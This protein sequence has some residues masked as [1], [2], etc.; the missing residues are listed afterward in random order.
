MARTDG[1]NGPLR[2]LGAA[3]ATTALVTALSYGVP[4]EHAASAVGLGFLAA[5]YFLTLRTND[6]DAARRYGLSLGGLLDVEPLSPARLGKSALQELG[7]A[8]A[9]CAVVLPP[10]W[11]GYRL[12]WSPAEPFRAASLASVLNDALGQFLVI[13]LP[14]EAFY[15]GYLQT[16]LDEAWPPRFRFLGAALGPGVVVTSVVFAL[17][18]L[19]TE[20][21]PNRLAVFFPSLLFGYLRSRR[22]G[23]GASAAFHASCNLFAA[24]L[25]RSYGL[26]G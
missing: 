10:F 12:W 24:F 15:R 5:T 23:I 3:F 26:G 21:H 4:A 20:L 11:I 14:E 22:G 7:V 8:L 6:P 16:S 13:A 19:A 1:K 17:G 2:P 9:V 18:H 25:A